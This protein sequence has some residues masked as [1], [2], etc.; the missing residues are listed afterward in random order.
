MPARY[1]DS[2]TGRLTDRQVRMPTQRGQG[3][4]E[5]LLWRPAYSPRSPSSDFGKYPKIR[6]MSPTTS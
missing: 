1:R 2:G 5:Q 6:A 4:G 3:F